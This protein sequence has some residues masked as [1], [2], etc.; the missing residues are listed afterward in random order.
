MAG[1]ELTA[2][3]LNTGLEV[4]LELHVVLAAVRACAHAIAQ[5]VL[6]MTKFIPGDLSRLSKCYFA[7]R[8]VS[9]RDYSVCFWSILKV[10][11]FL[12]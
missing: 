7:F 4:N 8:T 6:T 3:C 12:F 10:R 5:F 9:A 11:S 2:S 1:F